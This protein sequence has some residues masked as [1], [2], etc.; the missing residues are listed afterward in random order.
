MIIAWQRARM[1]VRPTQSQP[2]LPSANPRAADTKLADHG[3]KPAAT[4]CVETAGDDAAADAPDPPITMTRA[5]A[6]PAPSAAAKPA[7][8]SERQLRLGGSRAGPAES[9]GL[10]V[11]DNE[12]DASLI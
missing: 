9:C 10:P 5:A 2:S 11:Q 7:T 8:R 6:A 4:A 1:L 12:L 3:S